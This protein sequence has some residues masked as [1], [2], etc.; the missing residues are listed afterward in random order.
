MSLNV[1]SW[2]DPAAAVGNRGKSPDAYHSSQKLSKVYLAN[3]PLHQDQWQNVHSLSNFI[4]RDP[5]DPSIV[6]DFDPRVMAARASKYNKDNPSWDMVMGSPFEAEYW[7]AMEVELDTLYNELESWT[8]VKRTPSM[9]VL[10]LTWAFACKRRPDGDVKKFKARFVARGDRQRQDVNYFE[11]WDPVCHWSTIRTMMVISAKEKLYSAQCDITAAFLLAK[12]PK[13][14]SLFVSQPRG[15][16][17]DPSYVLKLNR[18]LYGL[19]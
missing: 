10:P 8:Y 4:S 11:T 2:G 14:E 1:C 5:W 13:R 3:C 9:R 17:M 19:K 6:E 18:T 7:A 16:M 15:F 12:L